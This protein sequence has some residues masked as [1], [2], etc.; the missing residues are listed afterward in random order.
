MPGMPPESVLPRDRLLRLVDEVS[1]LVFIRAPATPT[2][3]AP[4]PMPAPAPTPVPVAALAT[5]A[6]VPTPAE[7][8]PRIT[9]TRPT[10]APTV[11]APVPATRTEPARP[12][13]NK[14]ATRQAPGLNPPTTDSS[15]TASGP[16][17]PSLPVVPPALVARA[18]ELAAEYEAEHGTPITPGQLAVRLKVHSDE[19]AQA[20]AVLHLDTA[21]PPTRTTLNGQPV[22]ANR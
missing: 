8:A 19:A 13:A 12:R 11:S 7:V 9:P 21:Q 3:P 17:Q 4:A 15:V 1:P 14:A 20:F 18:R 2:V 22:K 6:E 10:T 16:V 5:V